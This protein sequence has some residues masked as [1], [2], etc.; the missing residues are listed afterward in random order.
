MASHQTIP[1]SITTNTTTSTSTNARKR[2][3][4]QNLP[5]S[6]PKFDRSELTD[7]EFIEQLLFEN[8]ELQAI[9]IN[10][11]KKISELTEA[12]KLNYLLPH[13]SHNN[14]STSSFD[15]AKSSRD[16]TPEVK[17]ITIETVKAITPSSTSL[18][19]INT[20]NNVDRTISRSPLPLTPT[21]E[22]PIIEPT[23]IPSRSS[24]R[25]RNSNEK[26]IPD[27]TDSNT[28][29]S[30]S[31]PNSSS[32]IS[33]LS[34]S[35]SFGKN[36]DDKT[37]ILN[38]NTTNNNIQDFKKD[39]SITPSLHLNTSNS[40]VS[41]TAR[42]PLNGQ[43]S[44]S[45]TPT[46]N[47]SSLTPI[48]INNSNNSNSNNNSLSNPIDINQSPYS[49]PKGNTGLSS[50]YKSKIKLPP[51]LQNQT[52]LG[53]K[54]P[55]AFELNTVLA[56]QSGTS[57]NPSNYKFSPVSQSTTQ[58]NGGSEVSSLK[59]APTTPDVISAGKFN[60]KLNDIP[61]PAL[62]VDSR[63][64][65]SSPV[66]GSFTHS[67]KSPGQLSSHRM[68]NNDVLRTPLTTE[69]D[70]QSK[71][72][73]Q[74]PGSSFNVLGTPKHEDDAKL[75]IKPEEFGVINL[76]VASTISVPTQK[77]TDD[78]NVTISI[79]DKESGQE[80]WRIRKTYSQL[81]A[82]DNEIR[83]VVQYFGL[84]TLPDK[85]VFL[86]TAPSKIDQRRVALQG[87]FK[88]IFHMPHI[89]QSIIYRICKYIS[90]DIISPLD[91]YKSGARKEG[92]LVRRYKGLGSS[93]KIRWC[94][95]DGP[96]LEIYEFPG[97]PLVEQVKL[98]GAQIGTQSQDSVA[99]DKGYRHGFL[100][101]EQQKS[102][103]LS[104]SLP[105]YFFCCEDDTERDAWVAALVEFS[106]VNGI[107]DTANISTESE[108][109]VD[110]LGS[111][112]P[113]EL[114]VSSRKYTNGSYSSNSKYSNDQA[115]YTTSTSLEDKEIKDAKKHKMRS[116]FQFGKKNSSQLSTENIL[117]EVD[118]SSIAAPIPSNTNMT[119][120]TS[121]FAQYLNEMQLENGLA[122]SIFGR[123]LEDAYNVSNHIYLSKSVP[124]I[125][126][127]CLDYLTRTGAIYEEGIFRLSGSA[128]AIRQLKDQFNHQYDVDLSDS[129]LHPDINTV[130]GLFKT[131]LREL[132][133]PIL[134]LKNYN[135]LHNVILQNQTLPP[136]SLANV[137][138]DYFNDLSNVDEIH[139]DISYVIFKFLTQIIAQNQNNRMNL[140]NV[141]IVFSPTLNISVEVLRV[142]LEDFECIFENGSP[143]ANEKR[144]VLDIHIPNF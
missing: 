109:F 41:S 92:Y 64:F 74:T 20:S 31:V 121:A 83:P 99:E 29:P 111:R 49:H 128:T 134:G 66:Q 23:E 80:M 12:S 6:H 135:H 22:I 125:I 142:F 129:E 136:T 30:L 124:S 139:Y 93:W 132:P 37:I 50:S 81:V 13:I 106:D 78:P 42:P 4:P 33:N 103:K 95:V 131:Y 84:P 114:E 86:A 108:D 100:I 68:D 10:K 76:I 137:F 73:A 55:A 21:E 85:S 69:F 127:R 35:T 75:V 89:P 122:K 44:S 112:Y 39:N 60:M 2:N 27:T 141:C 90:L 98:K 140:R 119:H 117:D 110:T 36:L 40:N 18:K 57:P 96:A 72:S 107:N 17:P 53:L 43:S 16:E 19:L 25:R 79:N 56:T 144:E 48:T 65:I 133:T 59:R 102:S 45:T 138:R 71:F 7:S 3:P 1:T 15:T 52:S 104:S 101:I 62:D 63:S 123:E 54:S 118:T 94:Q 143:L 70:S 51:T 61:N 113:D 28:S 32:N 115:S 47:H 8:R 77:K 87:Y 11:D 14:H 9:L 58:F 34:S 26:S 116:I 97:G 105:K 5:P 130:A 120:S 38:G 67:Q 46:S 126:Y 24:R 91:D 82:F 88:S